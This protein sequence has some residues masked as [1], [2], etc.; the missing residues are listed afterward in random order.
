MGR[1][2][3]TSLACATAILP[4]VTATQT[5]AYP[6]QSPLRV[7]A[8][9][10][11]LSK[12]ARDIRQENKFPLLTQGTRARDVTA[13][14][15]RWAVITRTGQGDTSFNARFRAG[16][17]RHYSGY[18]MSSCSGVPSWLCPRHP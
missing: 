2:L 7:R 10:T 1:R 13:C 8:C 18:P 6:A 14:H 16:S 11:T 5:A 12:V 4:L 3:I 15:G 9:K 17:W